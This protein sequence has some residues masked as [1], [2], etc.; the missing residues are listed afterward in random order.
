MCLSAWAE[1]DRPMFEAKRV[2][3]SPPSPPRREKGA[4]VPCERL[5]KKIAPRA[6]WLELTVGEQIV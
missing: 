6:Y 1:G 5:R 3:P 2:F 4:T